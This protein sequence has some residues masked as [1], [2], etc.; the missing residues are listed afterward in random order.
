MSGRLRGDQG[1]APREWPVAIAVLAV[2]SSGLLGFGSVFSGSLWW[3]RAVL[4]A[5]VVI[6]AITLLRRLLPRP[7]PRGKRAL[8]ALA[9]WG[10]G[11]IAGLGVLTLTTAPLTAILGVLPTPHTFATFGDLF[12]ESLYDLYDGV[13]PFAPS[14]AIM[15]LLTAI[16]GALAII[17]LWGALG[18]RSPLLVSLVAGAIYLGPIIVITPDFD[19]LSFAALALSIT[20]L[21]VAVTRLRDRRVGVVSARWPGMIAVSLVAVLTAAT[22]PSLAPVQEGGSGSLS[23]GAASPFATGINPMLALGDNLNRSRSSVAL[24]YTSTAERPLYLKVMNIDNL[25]SEVWQP[26]RFETTLESSPGNPGGAPGLN[27]EVAAAPEETTITI[28]ALTTEWLPLPYPA[29]QVTGLEGDWKW[30]PRGLT[31]QSTDSTTR[32]QS[33][34]VTSLNILATDDELRTAL[35]ELT[36][37]LEPYRG[38]PEDIPAS[39]IAT[40]QAVTADAETDYDRALALQSYFRSNFRYSTTAPVEENF[41]GSAYQVIESFLDRKSGYC[42]HFSSAMTVMARAL[43][44]P[45]RLAIGYL[46]GTSIGS[47]DNG[48]T[49]FE[50]TTDRL[51]AWPELYFEGFGWISFEPTATLG[52]PTGESAPNVPI[53][54]QEAITPPSPSATPTTRPETPAAPRPEAGAEPGSTGRQEAALPTPVLVT[55]GIAVLLSLPLLTRTCLR[56]LRRRRGRREGTPAGWAWVEFTATATDFDHQPRPG[57]S[58]RSFGQRIAAE[59]GLDSAAITQLYTDVERESYARPGAE[60]APAAAIET[61]LT[62][63]ITDLRHAHAPLNRARAALTPASLLHRPPVARPKRP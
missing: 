15:F 33:Y 30:E 42:V 59:L 31:V 16:A 44:I 5:A 10:G 29:Q 4:I 63:A 7:R 21:L 46:P 51:H 55:I 1:S 25:E 2:F 27:P 23:A 32:G 34:G 61:S 56:V 57:E 3:A 41:S 39:I 38:L 12:L 40:A 20:G 18:A 26:S 8:R 58:A 35:P 62:A 60:S 9:V 43:N 37:E 17:L 52:V 47:D 54:E 50:V 14:A 53:P 36:A 24:T 19:P 28:A 45:A 49:I 11:A 13:S 22:L 48:D 6:A